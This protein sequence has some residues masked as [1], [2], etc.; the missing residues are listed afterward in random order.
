MSDITGDIFAYGLAAGISPLAF[1]GT[2]A[3]LTTAAGRTSAAIFLAGFLV[4][5]STACVVAVLLAS[6]LVPP[7]SG[8]FLATVLKLVLGVF[9]LVAAW[10]E[11]PRDHGD[12]AG[13]DAM[14]VMLARFDDISP[15]ATFVAGALLTALPRRVITTILAGLAIGSVVSSATEG[16]ALVALYA[17]VASILI[18]STILVSALA[19]AR[20]ASLLERSRMWFVANAGVV[21]F[22]VSLLFGVLFTGQ[23]LIS[24]VS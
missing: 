16:L 14:K 17:L 15:R 3:I 24:I 1:L 5:I 10:R 21:V 23:A 7:D 6:V 8:D 2:V 12:S 18:W 20:G 9:L 11:R 4:T 22:G 19:G 13:A